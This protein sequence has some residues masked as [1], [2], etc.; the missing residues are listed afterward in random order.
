MQELQ[1]AV[2]AVRAAAGLLPATGDTFSVG[3]T[4]L[5]QQV[6]N[7]RSGLSVALSQLGIPFAFAEAIEPS[8]TVIKASHI[9]EL[10]DLV[11]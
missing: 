8:A 9:A 5:A 6:N 7:L 3:T 2:N 1:R 4:V 10:R 11:R